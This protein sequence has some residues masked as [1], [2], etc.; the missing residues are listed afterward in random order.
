MRVW[1]SGICGL[2]GELFITCASCA[3]VPASW[4]FICASK[5]IGPDDAL[6]GSS[7]FS[8]TR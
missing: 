8:L 3:L 1:K 6:F 4:V 7:I 5:S 2:F